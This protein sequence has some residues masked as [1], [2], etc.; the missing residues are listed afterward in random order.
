MILMEEITTE[1][2]KQKKTKKNKEKIIY[3]KY[4]KP[5]KIIAYVLFF[6]TVT[7]DI[8]AIGYCCFFKTFDGRNINIDR[9]KREYYE[10]HIDWYYS[11]YYEGEYDDFQQIKDI[12][13]KNT[14]VGFDIYKNGKSIYK[15]SKD[16]KNYYKFE[17]I[18]TTTNEVIENNETKS[19]ETRYTIYCYLDKDFHVKDDIAKTNEFIDLLYPHWLGMIYCLVIFT[20]LS[21]ALLIFIILSAGRKPNHKEVVTSRIDK[22]P[23]DILAIITAGICLLIWWPHECVYI[24]EV[25]NLIFSSITYSIMTIA[26]LPFVTSISRRVKCGKWWKNT[27]INKTIWAQLKK[28]WRSLVDGLIKIW[29]SLI[30]IVKN[31]N[32]IWRTAVSLTVFFAIELISVFDLSCHSSTVLVAFFF[33]L[34]LF[35]GALYV[36][37]ILRKLQEGGEKLAKGDIKSKIDTSRLFWDFKK[38]ANN[39][40]SINGGIQ[41]AVDEQLK[42]ERLKTELITNVSHDIKTPLT[43]IINYTDLISKEDCDNQKIVE[44]TEVLQRQSEK[45]KRL[46]ENL[47]DASKASTGNL[48]VNLEPCEVNVLLSQTAGEYEEKLKE[49]NLQLITKIP[50]QPIKIMADG[51]HLWRVFDNLMNNICKY[52]QSGTRVYLTADATNGEVEICFKN[53]SSTELNITADELMERFVRGDSSRNTEGN[54][55]GLNIA[56]SLTNIQNGTLSLK[57]DGDL[58]KVIIKFKTTS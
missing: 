31:L 21:I 5:A 48:S 44:Y 12:D 42:S 16:F 24:S 33:D 3:A 8:L 7:I 20:L 6:I 51:K 57:I 37:V 35:V 38:H 17:D 15:S 13:K 22:M 46:I 23:L 25:G 36:A 30:D 58:F 41:K 52:S 18:S 32:I 56:K 14:N 1:N 50:E 55:L 10:S 19:I 28:V 40:N 45:L 34:I 47:V 27:L 54:G 4:N 43:S 29:K 39:L 26:T 53:I 49:K 9:F 2:K 11:F